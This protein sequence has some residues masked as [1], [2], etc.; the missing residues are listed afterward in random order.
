[1]IIHLSSRQ[2]LKLSLASWRE[3][4]I[5][6]SLLYLTTS[7][8]FFHSQTNKTLVY[9]V[10]LAAY[11]HKLLYCHEAAMYTEWKIAL[12]FFNF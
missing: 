6:V 8:H 11:F 9:E 10:S 3:L 12:K 7:V 5:F 1:M 2:V 4:N